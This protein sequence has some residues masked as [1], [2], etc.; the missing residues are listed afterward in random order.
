MYEWD[1]DDY[2]AEERRRFEAIRDAFPALV[3]R[4]FEC[5]S[6]WYAIL[7]EFFAAV[8]DAIPPGEEAKW[9]L[10]QIKEKLGGLRI[11][12]AYGPQASGL[13]IGDQRK[14]VEAIRLQLDIA[15]RLAEHRAE[16]TCEVCCAR[17]RPTARMLD[18]GHYSWLMTRCP[19]HADGALPLPLRSFPSRY[20]I[21]DAVCRY[22]EEIDD[23]VPLP[24]WRLA[25][26]FEAEAHRLG[27]TIEMA[28]I[29]GFNGVEAEDWPGWKDPIPAARRGVPLPWAEARKLLDYYP[30]ASK[31]MG[32]ARRHPVIAWTPSWVLV[33]RY[34]FGEPEIIAL[35][36]HPMPFTPE[37]V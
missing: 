11:Y 35:P 25:A 19:K 6:G 23:F 26:E 17:G 24:R 27:E 2:R 33:S 18:N 1:T 7:H 15:C 13:Q 34:E 10:H 29:G 30:D 4:G 37:F 5:R 16:R 36:R 28:N 21:G 8:R 32:K 12:Y 31:A 3:T 22:D 20:H 9:D 14:T